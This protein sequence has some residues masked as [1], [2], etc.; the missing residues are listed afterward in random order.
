MTM[1]LDYRPQP[2]V[3]GG[4]GYEQN[5]YSQPQFTNPWQATASAGSPPNPLYQANYQHSPT[6]MDP[7]SVS[8]APPVYVANPAASSLGSGK[9]RLRLF[10]TFPFEEEEVRCDQ[11]ASLTAID[12]VPTRSYGS[13]YSSSATS[14]PAY[15]ATAGARYS[16][17]QVPTSHPYSYPQDLHRRDSYP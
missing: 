11:V 5:R 3:G 12:L 8:K 10:I 9:L 13:G 16:P 2:P 6:S 4:I 17:E 7:P 14:N 1:A 15:T